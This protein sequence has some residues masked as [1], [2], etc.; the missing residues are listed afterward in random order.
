MFAAVGR[1]MT[2]WS[3]VEEQLSRL[4]AVCIGG[5][6][7]KRV[8]AIQYIEVWDAMWIYFA[9]DN[10]H[11]RLQLVDAALTSHLHRTTVAEELTAEWDRL[12]KKARKLARRRGKLAHWTVIP[13]QRTGT[14]EEHEPIAPARLLPTIGSPKYYRETGYRPPGDALT[15]VQVGH[16]DRAFCLLRQKFRDFTHK[17]AGTEELRDKVARR[18]LDR[19]LILGRLDQN[20]REELIRAFP[21]PE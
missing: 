14:G 13:A 15:A 21:S 5:A 17:V 6:V 9:I 19:L 20:L 11:S 2:Q 16:L 3:F 18:G 12:A 7:L 8:G 4:M 1:A 10:F